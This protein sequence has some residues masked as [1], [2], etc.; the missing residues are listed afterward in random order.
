M[1]GGL[2][3]WLIRAVL[4]A[5]GLV[6]FLS[7][8]AAVLVLALAWALRALWARLTGRPVVPWT[9]RV[10]PR[11]GWSTVYRSSGRWSA[12]RTAPAAETPTRRAPASETP[13]R[14]AGV[15]PGADEVVDVE[16]REPGGPG[17]S[18]DTRGLH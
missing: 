18:G 14:R 12:A 15:L 13:T 16:P 9:M 10:D 1:F 6:M 17:G 4:V 2:T 8:L 3:R 5:A 7:L 11:T